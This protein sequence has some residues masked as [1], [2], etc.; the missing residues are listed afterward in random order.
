M[1]NIPITYLFAKCD[2]KLHVGS[3]IY[4]TMYGNMEI[5]RPPAHMQKVYITRNKNNM[6]KQKHKIQSNKH[7]HIKQNTHNTP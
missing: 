1:M 3:Y 4:A 5:I 6:H 7:K 2:K